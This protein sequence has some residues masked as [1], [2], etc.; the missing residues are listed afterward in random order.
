MFEEISFEHHFKGFHGAA[1]K[2]YIKIFEVDNKPLTVL[3]TPPKR[4]AGTSVMNAHE[5][6]RKEI[7]EQVTE[8]T[9]EPIKVVREYV[10]KKHLDE[11]L[12]DLST[13]YKDAEA[14]IPLF[15]IS[16]LA[17]M[18]G[19][20]RRYKDR[21]E[22]LKSLIWIEHYP[23]FAFISPRKDHVHLVVTLGHDGQHPE[24]K[25]HDQGELEQLTGLD[26][27]RLCPQYEDHGV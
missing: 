16:S 12:T 25:Y 14:D 1:S 19:Y 3:C 5:I 6:I 22:K 4:N 17:A 8:Q 23:P 13:K 2:C 20:I 26:F 7:D 18:L 11:M 21:K 15:C 9:P 24:W 27:S 10:G